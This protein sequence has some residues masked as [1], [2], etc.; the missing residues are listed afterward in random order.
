VLGSRFKFIK[1]LIGI[2]TSI[3][4]GWIY[5]IGRFKFIKSLIGIETEQ[6]EIYTLDHG[7]SN[8]SNP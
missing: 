1:S 4:V 8:S 7:D 2:E 5:A 6:K 3:G